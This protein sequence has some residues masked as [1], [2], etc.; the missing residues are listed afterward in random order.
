MNLSNIF[1]TDEQNKKEVIFGFSKDVKD[2][3]LQTASGLIQSDVIGIK[4]SLALKI[5]LAYLFP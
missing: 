4:W 2:M 1:K 5:L 3:P